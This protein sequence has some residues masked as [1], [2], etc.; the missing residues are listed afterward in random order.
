MTD[1][2]RF[3]RKLAFANML[4][5][6]RLHEAISLLEPGEF[7][8]PRTSF[9]PSLVATLN[10]ILIVDW[11]Y[12][13]ALEG[14]TLGPKAW[15]EEIP[16]PNPKELRNAQRTSDRR[17][18]TFCQSLRGEDTARPVHI[19]RAGR[20]QVER[21]DDVLSHLFQH[22]THHRGQ[23]HAMLAGT[24]IKPPQIDEFIVAD[25]AAS[26]ADAMQRLGLTEAEVMQLDS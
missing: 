23:A 20:I 10:H 25:D 7:E 9:F 3:I 13:D 16:F 19:H 21:T 26:R 4:A 22:Q 15:E 14:G 6:D 2:I 1:A 11:F 17:L 5:N 18:L 8:A 12:I 24:S